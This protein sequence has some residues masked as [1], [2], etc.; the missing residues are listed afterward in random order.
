MFNFIAHYLYPNDATP[1]A[2]LREKI[3]LSFC[4]FSKGNF[5]ILA[6]GPH[7]PFV[8][9]RYSGQVSSPLSSGKVR[10]SLQENHLLPPKN[11]ATILRLN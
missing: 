9:M 2:I 8:A 1:T 4:F 3:F 11:V 7:K 10:A 5:G 6:S